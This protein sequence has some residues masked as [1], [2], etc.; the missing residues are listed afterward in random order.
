VIANLKSGDH[1]V[2]VNKPYTWAQKIFDEILPGFNITTTYV[3]GTQIENFERAILPNTRIIYLET[4]NSWSFALQDLSAVAELAKAENIITICDN[5]FC[6]PLYQKPINHGIDLVLQSATKYIGG[7]SDVVAGVLTGSKT[8]IEKIF[9]LEFM[10]IGS[11]ISPFSAWLLL[12]GLRSLPVRLEKITDTTKKVISFLK[13]HECVE[14]VIFPLDDDFSQIDLAKKQMSGAC[15]LLTFIIKA[16]SV[17]ALESFCE[18]LRHI[19]LAVSWGGH[20]SLIIPG[21]ASINENQFEYTNQ[22]HRAMRLYVG[23]EEASY[24]IDDLSR[25]FLA[26]HNNT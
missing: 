11:G 12:R 7:H 10:A 3:D 22:N 26:I 20:E 19:L 21:C 4:P 6:T 16:D 24:I 8:M 13:T 1:I 15:G 9:Q 17:R 14:K 25:G 23:L 2:S 5:S 18:N